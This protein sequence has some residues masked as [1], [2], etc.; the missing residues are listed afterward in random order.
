MSNVLYEVTALRR[1]LTYWDPYPKCHHAQLQLR[2]LFLFRQC[3]AVSF[4]V[5]QWCDF[6]GGIVAKYSHGPFLT[7]MHLTKENSTGIPM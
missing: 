7:S 1:E 3:A 2:V 5:K 4:F 6:S